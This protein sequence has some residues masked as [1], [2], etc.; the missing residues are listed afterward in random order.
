MSRPP[1]RRASFWKDAAIVVA[2]ALAG[3]VAVAA[4]IA[5]F[6]P[7]YLRDFR[8][9]ANPDAIHYVMLGENVWQRGEYSRLEA[10]PY[11]PDILRPPVYPLLAGGMNL[12]A[13][14]IWPLYALQ[15][16]LQALTAVAVYWFA[17]STFGRRAGLIAGVLV[18]ADAVMMVENFEAM[19]EGLYVMLATW[20]TVLW[21]AILR[22]QPARP[23]GGLAASA[24]ALLGLATLTRPAGVY[25]PI[26]LLVASLVVAA[27]YRSRPLLRW[28]LIAIAVYA[29]FVVPWMARNYAVF[30]I[31]RMTITDS[32][33]KVYFSGAGAIAEDEGLAR[34]EAQ[35]KIAR[36][37]D[38]ETVVV[39]HNYWR[40]ER[41]VAE[42]D[43][44]QRRAYRQIVASHPRGLA[45][46]SLKGFAK[47]MLGHDVSVLAHATG[48]EWH[49][50]RGLSKNHPLLQ[51]ALVYQEAFTL[52]VLLAA[53]IGYVL[54]LR[55]RAQRGLWLGLSAVLAYYALT[56]LIVGL[57]AYTRHRLAVTPLMA[58]LAGVTVTFFLS[59]GRQPSESAPR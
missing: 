29:V 6:N 11:A 43:A 52:L 38:L 50:A 53:A 35:A 24:G 41:S 13:G 36:D 57:D 23:V 21:L 25:L 58:V 22:P 33:T 55:D 1:A 16:I 19:S 32:L 59:G 40:S 26:A 5:G 10:P 4:M 34:E 56:I 8:S 18:A 20:G 47:A 51:I 2:I 7:G 9:N 27:I 49:G 3:N 31:P 14:S 44:A 28:S 15:A 12:L 54:L 39:A 37:Y 46:S 17:A 42:M 45:I 48:L 30:G